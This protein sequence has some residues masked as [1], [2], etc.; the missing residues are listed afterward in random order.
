MSTLNPINAADLKRKL[1]AGEAVLV[2]IR[3][4]NEHAQE[5]IVE[6]RLAPLSGFDPEALADCRDKIGVFHCKSG[7]RTRTNAAG[8]EVPGY[9][10][11]VN[12]PGLPA[13]PFMGLSQDDG[14]A[15]ERLAVAW[16]E[17]D[18]IGPGGAPA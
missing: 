10:K 4:P 3:E 5:H 9:V 6:A 11:K 2:D 18:E 13:R 1:E 7:M 8:A 12:H 16:L 17:L 14:E 15:I